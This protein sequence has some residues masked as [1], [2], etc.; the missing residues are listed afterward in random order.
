MI[1]EKFFEEPCCEA[2]QMVRFLSFFGVIPAILA[3]LLVCRASHILPVVTHAIGTTLLGRHPH[4]CVCV[5]IPVH[6]QTLCR[7]RFPMQ[8]PF[9]QLS[10]WYCLR[11]CYFF[12]SFAIDFHCILYRARKEP[13]PFVIARSNKACTTARPKAPL[14]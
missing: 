2:R 8:Q 13:T 11:G 3:Q 9:P 4:Q 14:T 12:F 6:E 7:A 5:S 10:G 1:D